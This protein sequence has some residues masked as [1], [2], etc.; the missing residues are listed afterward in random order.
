MK[1]DLVVAVTSA[2]R[3]SIVQLERLRIP[4]F[5]VDPGNIN[6]TFEAIRRI[7]R[8][9]GQDKEANKVVAQM[10]A[11]AKAVENRI[12]G[13]TLRPKVL[14]VIQSQP[15][16]VAGSQTFMDEIVTAAGGINVGRA[17]GPGYNL[18]SPER[19]V[20]AAPDVIIGATDLGSKPGWSN[21]QAVRNHKILRPP[22]DVFSR[23]GPRLMDALEFMAR[24]LHPEAFDMKAGL[25]KAST[26]G[27]RR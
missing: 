4:V 27:N 14:I 11:R 24:T 17:S 5:A 26:P 6:E 20:V 10:E 13:Q 18:F 1:P 21:I 19:A 7:G 8:I 25:N 2:N 16:M 15:L 23:P 3:S 12:S 9:T 22:P